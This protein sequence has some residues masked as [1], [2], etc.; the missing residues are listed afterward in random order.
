M[1]AADTHPDRYAELLRLADLFETT[2][3]ELR[4]R[5][6]LG[7]SVLHDPAVGDSAELAP[8]T[9]ER[10]DEELRTAT[11]GHRGLLAHAVELDADALVVRATV[12][13]YRWIDDLQAAAVR[14]LGSIAGRAIGYL[15]PQVALGGAVVSAG[16]IE[17]DALDRDEVAA[18]LDELVRDNPTLLDHVSGAGGLLDG[19]E[20]RSLLTTGE[21][22]SGAARAGLRAIGADPFPAD[23]GSA[24]RDVAAAAADGA[25]PV[26]PTVDSGR[27]GG[28]E[29]LMTALA[30]AP[31]A[32]SVRQVAPSR[33]VAFLPGPSADP[34]TG[35]GAP[36]PPGLVTGD[37]TAY[38][39]HAVAAIEEAVGADARV[40]LV[41]SGPGGA[42]AV[43]IA[44]RPAP[45]V[46]EQVVTAGAPSAL[47]PRVPD[48]VRV[49]S[50]EDRTDPVALL[51]SLV[52]ADAPNRTTVV[53]DG[54]GAIGS[55]AYV[56]GGR[57]ADAA[58]HPELRQ[59]LDR[60]RA[61]GYLG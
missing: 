20:L 21:T 46:V 54:G 12:R 34:S 7:A 24:A 45:F 15:A 39:H 1:R 8:A 31:A 41:G 13:T 35:P 19:L 55:A 44:T 10:V 36:E 6:S 52:N 43:D 25:D 59:E 61:L 29:E 50:L 40:M 57:A 30:T 17:T 4:D 37:H 16:L 18:Y 53:F 23:L 56:A 2:A 51:G 49:L 32:V 33:Y 3:A 28:L 58:D 60:L 27:L 9:F 5:A 26:R 22:S 42:T 11:A 47:V 38:A 14:T 48:A